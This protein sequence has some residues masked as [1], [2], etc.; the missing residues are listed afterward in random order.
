MI[1]VL[2]VSFFFS[3]NPVCLSETFKG[4]LLFLPE[5]LGQTTRIRCSLFHHASSSTSLSLFCFLHFHDLPLV[6]SELACLQHL[7]WLGL[8]PHHRSVIA[9]VN[10]FIG[11]GWEEIP[12]ASRRH[13]RVE[14]FRCFHFPPTIVSSFF[15]PAIV[16][17]SSLSSFGSSN[18]EG[19]RYPTPLDEWMYLYR[20]VPQRLRLRR[21]YVFLSWKF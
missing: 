19:R 1:A 4:S 21:A 2:C 3:F 9:C 16:V 6:F 11:A 7:G 10:L 5:C 13:W 14:Y 17:P 18:M 12:F 15:H 20:P 8:F